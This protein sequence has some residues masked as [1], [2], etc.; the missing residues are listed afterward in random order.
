MNGCPLG[1]VRPAQDREVIFDGRG[2]P[3]M[4]PTTDWVVLSDD[5][6]NLTFDLDHVT[7]THSLEFDKVD[8]AGNTIYAGV[9][10][11]ALALN[12]S[13]FLHGDVLDI[14]CSLPDLTNVAEIEVRLGTDA[15]NYRQWIVADTDLGTSWN[16]EVL[17]LDDADAT[18]VGNG[19]DP[20]NVKYAAFIVKF[21]AEGNALADILLDYI[22]LRSVSRAEA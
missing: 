12:L 9:V 19:W 1:V 5:T 16:T 22:G 8:G 15:S 14:H 18:N 3:A 6:D 7:G 4:I 10:N 20:A 13:R 17:R 21:D 11:T 2:D